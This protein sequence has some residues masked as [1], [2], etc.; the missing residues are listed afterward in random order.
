LEISK[1]VIF[2]ALTKEMKP[3]NYPTRI[4]N[5]GFSFEAIN[6]SVR[7]I[8]SPKWYGGYRSQHSYELEPHIITYFRESRGVY[9][10]AA[11]RSISL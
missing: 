9:A 6:E 7:D 5:P 2:G 11:S 4:L 1:V 10:W 3:Q 8:R